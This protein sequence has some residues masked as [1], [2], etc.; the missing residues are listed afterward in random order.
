MALP[1]SY[2]SPA[3]LFSSLLAASCAWFMASFAATIRLVSKSSP[4]F[5]SLFLNEIFSRLV[6]REISDHF[7]LFQKIASFSAEKFTSCSPNVNHE[8]TPS[9]SKLITIL[10]ILHNHL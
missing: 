1:V 7:A 5:L 9:P 8:K 2:L 4:R 6:I 10:H 3:E